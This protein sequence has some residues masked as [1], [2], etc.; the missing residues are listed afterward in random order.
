MRS[1]QAK[2]EK[3]GASLVIGA[4]LG[5]GSFK[6]VVAGKH[7][8]PD[9][10]G[11]KS[12]AVVTARGDIDEEVSVG[13]LCQQEHELIARLVFWF[14]AGSWYDVRYVYEY[15]PSTLHHLLPNA[16]HHVR[17]AELLDRV[18]ELLDVLAYL[19]NRTVRD[20]VDD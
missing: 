1:E 5:Q 13:L 18:D 16:K 6:T 11:E 20:V 15:Y 17:T 12:V 10:G 4:P 14:R 8:D 2:R 19:H 9:T 3:P 7:R